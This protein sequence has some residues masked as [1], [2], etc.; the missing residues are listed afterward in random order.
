MLLALYQQTRKYTESLCA[1]LNIEDYIPQA[2]EFTSPPKW[3][4]AHTTWFFEEMILT[5]FVADY[6]V[7]DAHFGYLF[8]S[9]YQSVGEKAV[10]AQ[11]GIITRPTVEQVYQYRHYVD[12]YIQRLLAEDIPGRVKALVTLGINHEQQHQ[13]LLLT[14]LKYTLSLNPLCPVYRQDC[15]LVADRDTVIPENKQWLAIEAG[16]YEVGHA[17]DS[18][19]FDNE[20]ERHKVYLQGFEIADSLVTNG[21]YIEFMESGGYNTF[22]YWLDDGWT[23]L[24]DN[25]I[26]CP[27]YWTK[28]E[29]QWHYYTLAGLKPVDKKA[30][31][32]HVS[33]YEANAFAN[34]KNMRLAT[35]FEWE[36]ASP[37]FDWGLRWEWTSSAYQAYPG[38]RASEGA[39]GEYNGK[40][41]VNQMVLRGASAATTQNHSRATYRN[42]FQPHFQWQYSGIRLVK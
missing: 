29:G 40:F 3:H 16:I 28:I 30:I 4:L 9:Y 2:V 12:K 14:D 22:S 21:E 11:R 35:E 1:P 33:Y 13:E 19:C 6:A 31:L 32:A 38:F 25:Q 17:G 34:W 27:L 36:V 10:R 5:K 37:Q 41:M 7:F 26:N 20:R 24:C 42:F 39:V 8:N 15:N 23:W 18:F